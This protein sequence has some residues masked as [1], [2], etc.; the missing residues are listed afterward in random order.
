[1]ARH[2]TAA[3]QP[4]VASETVAARRTT[5]ILPPSA[6]AHLAAGGR[7]ITS[8]VRQLIWDSLHLFDLPQP[9]KAQLEADMEAL[10]M[11]TQR[12]YIVWLLVGR[13]TQLAAARPRDAA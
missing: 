10:G 7:T 9:I 11:A 1:M 8:A 13:H 6:K 2:R 12:D 5:I 3:S 4:A